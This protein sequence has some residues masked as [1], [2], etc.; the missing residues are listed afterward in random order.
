MHMCL[1]VRRTCACMCG[2]GAARCALVWVPSCPHRGPP[3]P[4]SKAEF[5]FPRAPNDNG[6]APQ[7]QQRREREHGGAQKDA[8][9]ADR[10]RQRDHAGACRGSRQPG[11]PSAVHEAPPEPSWLG[12]SSCRCAR[13]A[14]SSTQV[15]QVAWQTESAKQSAVARHRAGTAPSG[16]ACRREEFRTHCRCHQVGNAARCAA[17]AARPP[18]RRALP[19]CRFGRL[20]A[21]AAAALQERLSQ[22][23]ACGAR[24]FH[25]HLNGHHCGAR[26]AQKRRNWGRG[27]GRASPSALDRCRAVCRKN[28]QAQLSSQQVTGGG[29]A[30]QES[31]HCFRRTAWRLSRPPVLYSHIVTTCNTFSH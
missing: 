21:A 25:E 7:R 27:L 23:L 6:R 13:Q 16:Q 2:A 5:S 14:S 10:A 11:Q 9:F 1:H 28:L 30:A 18:G 17:G 20:A 26:A 4:S 29:A 22:G 24:V 15:V 31:P 8:C 12:S 3:F 19:I